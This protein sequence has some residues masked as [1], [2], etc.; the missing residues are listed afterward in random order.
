VPA[1]ENAGMMR[2]TNE[3][4]R[5]RTRVTDGEH[6]LVADTTADKGG[7]GAGFRPHDLLEGALAACVAMTV[8]MYAESKGI[9]LKGVR[10]EVELDRSGT[11][12]AVLRYRVELEGALSE[13]ERAR[14]RRAAAACP[15]RRTLE[16]GLTFA[17][18]G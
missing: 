13:E 2:A 5:Y 12:A 6:E 8:R 15:V 16:R 9:G 17:L 3:E 7:Q 10:V 11:G 4:A 14:L 18:E 1:W